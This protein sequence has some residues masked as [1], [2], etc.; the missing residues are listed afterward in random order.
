MPQD[1]EGIN[2]DRES[3]RIVTFISADQYRLDYAFNR[4]TEIS[5]LG[6]EKI[7]SKTRLLP[8]R[9][10]GMG[11]KINYDKRSASEKLCL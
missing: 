8:A 9:F 3:R 10:G 2:E 5:I 11:E 7:V 1:G 6:Q 4:S